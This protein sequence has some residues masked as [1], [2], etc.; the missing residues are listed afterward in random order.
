MKS[1]TF[2]ENGAVE[3]S[4]INL[5]RQSPTERCGHSGTFEAKRLISQAP[6]RQVGKTIRTVDRWLDQ[7]TH[8][9][10]AILRSAKY[11]RCGLEELRH[12]KNRDLSTLLP[13]LAEAAGKFERALRGDGQ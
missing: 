1:I 6:A 10:P 11:L 8:R 12:N 13:A 5:E 2:S 7:N 3:R 9:S 4:A